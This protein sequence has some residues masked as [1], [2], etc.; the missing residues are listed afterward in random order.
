MGAWLLWGRENWKLAEPLIMLDLSFKLHV[1]RQINEVEQLLHNAS[2]RQRLVKPSC[3]QS[4][5]SAQQ[6]PS[7]PL[8]C[9]PTCHQRAQLSSDW[10]AG[11]LTGLWGPMGSDSLRRGRPDGSEWQGDWAGL[12]PLLL[13]ASSSVSVS[14][15]RLL[16]LVWVFG[17]T[18]SS[19]PAGKQNVN[20]SYKRP[21]SENLDLCKYCVLKTPLMVW[22]LKLSNLHKIMEIWGVACHVSST[23]KEPGCF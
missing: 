6:Q 13:D 18:T 17:R 16:S 2:L 22:K 1:D 19:P 3:R 8:I 23:E 21:R 10:L 5:E 9:P 15:P 7:A 20:Q 12:P 11:S 14:I 4:D